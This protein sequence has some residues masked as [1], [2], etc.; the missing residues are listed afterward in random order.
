MVMIEMVVRVVFEMAEQ[1]EH[2]CG[3]LQLHCISVGDWS[4]EDLGGKLE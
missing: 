1:S 4:H 2:A 3:M